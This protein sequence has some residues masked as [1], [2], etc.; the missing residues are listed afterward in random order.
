MKWKDF[1]WLLRCHGHQL[2]LQLTEVATPSDPRGRTAQM[3]VWWTRLERTSAIR[4]GHRSVG[5][6][7]P[8]MVLLSL[9]LGPAVDAAFCAWALETSYWQG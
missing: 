7:C 6:L 9:Q 4:G 5:H 1:L 8:C 3:L 2:Y